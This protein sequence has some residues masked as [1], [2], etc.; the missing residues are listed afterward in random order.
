MSE[1]PILR[2]NSMLN[3]Y[4]HCRVMWVESEGWPESVEP[5]YALKLISAR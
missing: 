2:T 3:S 4:V 1:E 5:M